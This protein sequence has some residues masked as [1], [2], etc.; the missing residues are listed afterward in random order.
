MAFYTLLQRP[1]EASI[2]W[3]GTFLLVFVKSET[4][5][6]AGVASVN[7]VLGRDFFLFFVKSETAP[8]AGVASVN[9]ALHLVS[10]LA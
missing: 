4:A 2:Y 5:P 8:G 7:L 1:G 9:L 6:G 10:T 3:G